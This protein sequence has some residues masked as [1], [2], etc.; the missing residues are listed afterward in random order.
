MECARLEQAGLG[1]LRDDRR[2]LGPRDVGDRQLLAVLVIF[3]MVVVIL[4]MDFLILYM[5]FVILYIAFV[6]LY[7]DFDMF[8]KVFVTFYGFCLHVITVLR[9]GMCSLAS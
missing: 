1:L 6:I 5:V 3:Y 7:M 9:A 8:Y 2:P 4:H